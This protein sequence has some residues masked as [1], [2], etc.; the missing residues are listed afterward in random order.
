MKTNTIVILDDEFDRLDAMIPLLHKRYPALN[1]VTFDN[2]PDINKWLGD[3]LLTCVLIC[4]D[5]DLGANRNRDGTVFDPGVGQN[6]ADYLASQIPVCKIIL[7]TTNTDARPGMIR[8]LEQ[9]G[10]DV[11]YVSPYEGLLWVGEAWANEVKNA[12]W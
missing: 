12:L 8:T 7:H 11:S 6:V 5:H 4:L 1:V 9:A 3:N 10:W 2:A